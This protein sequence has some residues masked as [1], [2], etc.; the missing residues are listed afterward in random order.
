MPSRLTGGVTR[1][2]FLQAGALG[3]S[4]GLVSGVAW[5]QGVPASQPAGSGASGRGASGGSAG[6]SGSKPNILFISADQLGR[7]A[8]SG[9]GCPDVNTPNIDRL[10]KSGQSFGQCYTANPL[11]SPARSSWFTGRMPSETAVETNRL[12]IR[13][14]MPTMGNVL[15]SGGYET[16]Y[17]GKWHLPF[18]CQVEIEGFRVL[19]GGINNRGNMGDT[20]VSQACQGLL[21][22]RGS[23]QPFLLVASFLQPHDVCSWVTEHSKNPTKQLPPELTEAQLPQLPANFHYD[24]R[25]PVEMTH[26]PRWTPTQ[27]RYYLWNYYRHV[28]MVDAEVGRIL[29]AVEDTP[30]ADNTLIMFTSDHGE[31]RAHHQSVMKNFLYDEAVTVPLIYSWPGRIAAGARDATHLVSS[32]DF[33][34][35]MCD[36]AGV[37]TPARVVG[38]SLRPLL[39]GGNPAWRDMVAAEV[40]VTGRMIRSTQYKYITYRGDPVEQLFDMANDPGETKNLIGDAKFASALEDHRKVLEDWESRLDLPPAG[41]RKPKKPKETFEE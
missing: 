11:C 38:Q 7:E 18:E 39:E 1:R 5:G 20:A 22:N 24:H 13:R 26:R 14:G 40:K 17:C 41:E 33:L 3:A 9:S 31:G 32:T 15:R 16:F 30:Y 6:V 34:P 25:E 27:W 8:L 36:Y 10:L 12:H 21:K 23:K 37:A 4:A 28:E 29:D 35:T 2:E 19:P